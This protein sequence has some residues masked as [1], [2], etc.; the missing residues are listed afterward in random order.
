V[1]L[2]LDGYGESYV[3]SPS[4]I[5]L[6][7]DHDDLHIGFARLDQVYD[8]KS[9]PTPAPELCDICTTGGSLI[10]PPTDFA[11]WLASLPGVEVLAP[12]KTV[13]VGGLEASQ[14]DVRSATGVPIGPL[15]GF[16]NGVGF[17]LGGGGTRGRLIA[18]TVSGRQILIAM[19][20]G[21]TERGQAFIDSIVWH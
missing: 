7:Y 20:Q 6:Q 17:G 10:D 14:L 13:Q 3:D 15:A 8:P 21:S 1:T 18:V 16:R 5:D 19:S 9:P 11:S 4:W 2:A 12:A